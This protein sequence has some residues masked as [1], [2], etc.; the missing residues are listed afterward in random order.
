MNSEL[1]IEGALDWE[2]EQEVY[3]VEDWVIMRKKIRMYVCKC[4]WWDC[5]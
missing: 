3:K 2:E 5:Y 1:G 4:C